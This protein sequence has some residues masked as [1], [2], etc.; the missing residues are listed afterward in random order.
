M[1]DIIDEYILKVVLLYKNVLRIEPWLEGN[2]AGHYTTN[3]CKNGGQISLYIL[4]I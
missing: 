4:K 3:Y 1:I 2:H